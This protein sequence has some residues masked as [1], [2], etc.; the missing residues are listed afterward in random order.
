MQREEL[1]VEKLGYV[2]RTIKDALWAVENDIS[3]IPIAALEESRTIISKI[4]FKQLMEN[5]E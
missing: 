1:E 5:K 3:E 4:I 2:S